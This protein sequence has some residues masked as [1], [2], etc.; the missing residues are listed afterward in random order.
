MRR[1]VETI[2]KVTKEHLNDIQKQQLTQAVDGFKD[3]CLQT[4]SMVN[5]EGKVIQKT[6][7]STPL[8]STITED[9][10]KFQEMFHQAMHHA[11]INQSKIMTNSV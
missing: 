11:L 3:A 2:I 4:F 1:S 6:N 5:R 10:V 8:H 9:F 7:F